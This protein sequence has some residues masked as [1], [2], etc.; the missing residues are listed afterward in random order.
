MSEPASQD[1]M[2]AI[3]RR[4]ARPRAYAGSRAACVGP[5]ATSSFT[6]G[7]RSGLARRLEI[8]DSHD[9]DR[10]ADTD[11]AVTSSTTTKRPSWPI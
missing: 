6:T 2:A 11:V 8:R 3:S 4:G 7:R 1:A 10:D 5:L 9:T